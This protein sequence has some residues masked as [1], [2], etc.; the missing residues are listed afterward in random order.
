ME[1]RITMSKDKEF[2]LIELL[3]VIAIIAILAAML[4]PALSKAREKARQSGCT[5]NS[6][7]IM[8]MAALYSVD[9]D[10]YVLPSNLPSGGE[11]TNNK[12]MW[13]GLLYVYEGVSAKTFDCPSNQIDVP[14]ESST[15]PN[16]V[17]PSWFKDGGVKGNRKLIW[18]IKLG[19]STYAKYLKNT[20][21]K[22][23]S[24]DIG[25]MDGSWQN[26]SNPL[27]GYNHPS[28]LRPSTGSGKQS[29][30]HNGKFIFGMLDGHVT[31]VTPLEYQN[32]LYGN[33]KSD[34]NIKLDGGAT[35]YVNN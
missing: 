13:F 16:F 22:K 24:M 2:T 15:A 10:D 28:S 18:N 7:T 20:S 35:I 30:V 31:S 29:P 25:L 26:G 33:G 23:A 27:S 12:N 3:V 11:L 17:Q 9:Y 4:L 8:L 19:H 32:Q 34:T 6:R 14:G 5:N 21:L 1:K